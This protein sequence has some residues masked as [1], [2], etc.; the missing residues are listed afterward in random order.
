MFHPAYD[1]L[2][3]NRKTGLNYDRFFRPPRFKYE[4]IVRIKPGTEPKMMGS[5][6]ISV[7]KLIR[8]VVLLIVIN[9][10]HSKCF[11]LLFCVIG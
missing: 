8:I 7:L 5:T 1:Q 2:G 10:N 11:L 3:L 6:R 4:L 9:F